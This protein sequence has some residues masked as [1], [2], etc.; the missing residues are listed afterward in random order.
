MGPH[1]LG[2]IDH[3]GLLIVFAIVL[4]GQMGIPIPA[5]V[6]LISAGTLAASGDLSALGAFLVAVVACLIAD[7]IWFLIG[8]TYGLRVLTAIYRLSWA[9]DAR[10]SKTER[11]FER[12]GSRSLIVAKF[13]PGLSTIAPPLAGALGVG[14]PQFLLLSGIGSVLWVAAG[15]AT[16]IAFAEQI[17]LLIVHLDR[18][19]KLAT[20]GVGGL[21]VGYV[22]YRWWIRRRFLL[23]LRMARI[24]IN[25]LH[26]LI[27][28]GTAPLIVD[29]RIGAARIIEPRGIPGAVRAPLEDIGEGV[30]KLPRNRDIVLYCT[31]PNEAAVAYVAKQLLNHGFQRVR[32]LHGGLDAWLAA[33]YAVDTFSTQMSA[34]ASP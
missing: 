8:K 9:S 13:I 11:R 23:T 12:W 4:I 19:G 16:G 5:I 29:A 20:V 28:A 24:S 34:P 32:P 31:C 1:L 10:V 3:Y 30:E 27:E 25:T 26:Q 22:V 33:G 21:I 2:L 7:S 14:W 18:V 6:A 17:P 15:L